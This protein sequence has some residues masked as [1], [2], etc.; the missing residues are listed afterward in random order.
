[1]SARNIVNV[2]ITMQESLLKHVPMLLR[3]HL[4]FSIPHA[5]AQF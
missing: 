3:S 1:M 2:V 5:V 4:V